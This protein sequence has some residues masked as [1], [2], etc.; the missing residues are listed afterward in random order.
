[1]L[2]TLKLPPRSSQAGQQL[3]GSL[4]DL[5]Q[6]TGTLGHGQNAGFLVEHPGFLDPFGRDLDNIP[7]ALAIIEQDGQAFQGRQARRLGPAVSIQPRSNFLRCDRVQGSFL[8]ELQTVT[9]RLRA[10]AENSR[11]SSWN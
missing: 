3:R 10:A 8:R 7:A 11:S 9:K 2:L 1:M 5:L 6:E 4:A